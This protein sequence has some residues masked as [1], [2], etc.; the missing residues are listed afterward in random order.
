MRRDNIFTN[1][2]LKFATEWNYRCESLGEAWL[3]NGRQRDLLELENY[4][5]LCVG[6]EQRVGL[7][8]GRIVLRVCSLLNA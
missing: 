5:V 4:V 6:F 7:R 3:V 8:A 2:S 1:G